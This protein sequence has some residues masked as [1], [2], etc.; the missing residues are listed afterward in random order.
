MPY[1]WNAKLSEWKE[2]GRSL[3]GAAGI[4]MFISKVPRLHSFKWINHIQRSHSAEHQEALS[5]I[6]QTLWV[7]GRNSV[8]HVGVPASVLAAPG[9]LP[10]FGGLLFSVWA[11]LF[12]LRP[13]TSPLWAEV[14]LDSW[15]P[16]NFKS[17]DIEP[18]WQKSV[19]L[20]LSLCRSGRLNFDPSSTL[21]T[22]SA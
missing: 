8:F 18:A 3:H 22:N 2:S 20:W 17:L 9:C 6:V 16:A 21:A 19:Q 15:N 4:L 12:P 7:V 5:K 1:D 13:L 11:H 14:P 10:S